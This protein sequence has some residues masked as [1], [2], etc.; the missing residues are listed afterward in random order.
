MDFPQFHSYIHYISAR[1]TEIEE[2]GARLALACQKALERY[3]KPSLLGEYGYMGLGSKSVMNEDDPDG[4]LLHNALWS[5]VLSG[6]AGTP[7]FWWWDNYIH[8]N[9]LYRHYGA[10]A[11]F[12]EPV[13]WGQ[14][15]IP[16]RDDG[17]VV[18]LVGL[19]GARHS[20]LWLQ[21]RENTWDKRI[22]KGVKPKNIV[23]AEITLPTLKQGRWRVEWMDTYTGKVIREDVLES[24]GGEGQTG[25]GSIPLRVPSFS[26]DI[27][28]RITHLP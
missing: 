14:K 6:S 21:N 11:K 19:L 26:Y 27:A 28:V 10:L 15:F 2:D 23:G 13:E 3:G 7:M 16:V 8:P 12:A 25:Y 22:N 1:R 20:L 4:V 17:A 9:G 24:S 18:R 5:G